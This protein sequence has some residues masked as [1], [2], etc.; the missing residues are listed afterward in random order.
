VTSEILNEHCSLVLQHGIAVG[1]GG[2]A[3]ARIANG[4]VY[5]VAGPGKTCQNQGKSEI[6][7]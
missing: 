3:S 6:P 7:H 2:I 4:V 5:V 1:L